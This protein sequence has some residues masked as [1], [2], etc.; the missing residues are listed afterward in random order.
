MSFR[1]DSLKGTSSVE[2][3]LGGPEFAMFQASPG[4]NDIEVL[5]DDKSDYAQMRML[6]RVFVGQTDDPNLSTTLTD[7][8]SSNPHIEVYING[9]SPPTAASVSGKV[10]FCHTTGGSFNENGLYYS[11]GVVFIEVPKSIGH[12]L[13]TDATGTTGNVPLE[14][15]SIFGW[16]IATASWIKCGSAATSAAGVL[17]IGVTVGTSSVS[18]SAQIPAGAIVQMVTADVT[19]LYTGGT[20]FIVECDGNTLASQSEIGWRFAEKY[21]T[22]PDQDI[23]GADI[24]S[25]TF[26]GTPSAGA[27]K[28]TIY[29]SVPQT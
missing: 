2:F 20:S 7:L 25:V 8:V 5:L 10:G 4:G 13:T 1:F 27:M 15:S 22:I 16:N 14:G 19:T 18:S 17:S 12:T 3:W 23:A 11:N 9:G 21:S 29:Y 28:V 24:V 6:G 26:T